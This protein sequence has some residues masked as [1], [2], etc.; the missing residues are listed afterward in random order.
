MSQQVQAPTRRWASLTL[1]ADYIGVSERTIRRMILSGEVNGYRFGPRLL[2]VDL[3]ELD[4]RA[5]A[6]AVGGGDDAA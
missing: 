6:G 3:D 2:R 1:A 4:A 5:V